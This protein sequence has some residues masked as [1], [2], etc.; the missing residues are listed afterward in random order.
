MDCEVGRTDA[1]TKADYF[2]VPLRQTQN[3]YSW[4]F[5]LH[6][7]HGHSD[8]PLFGNETYV[9]SLISAPLVKSG[10][11]LRELPDLFSKRAHA[12]AVGLE[13]RIGC[14]WVGKD[15]RLP[16]PS[17]MKALIQLIADVG[18]LLAQRN[19]ELIIALKLG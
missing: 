1:L 3:G 6:M 4:L 9:L 14:L 7:L 10:T 15:S 2:P 8:L 16:D 19:I 17:A 5:F 12:R 18:R 11:C 13:R